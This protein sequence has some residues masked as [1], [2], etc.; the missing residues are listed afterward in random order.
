MATGLDLVRIA[1]TRIGCRYVLGIITPKDDPN[2]CMFDCAEFASWSIYQATKRLYGC[3]NNNGKPYGADAFSG[4]WARDAK[5]L[6]ILISVEEAA[7]TAGCFLI[8]LAGHGLIGHVAMTVGDNNTTIEAHS[9]KTGVGQWGISGRR[10]DLAIQIPFVSY[11]FNPPSPVTPPSSKIYRLTEP[12]MHDDFIKKI[13]QALGF[14]GNDVDGYYGYKTFTAVRE[15]QIKEG[16]VP[17]GEAGP[18]TLK[19]LNL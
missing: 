7:S 4:Y 14:T 11:S 3:Y 6:G 9:T 1:R 13:Q 10:W 5:E 12:M 17:D 19:C 2:A 16:L 8:R 15:F 18:I